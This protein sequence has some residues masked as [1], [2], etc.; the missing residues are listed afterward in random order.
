MIEYKGYKI[1]QEYYGEILSNEEKLYHYL[2]Y[3]KDGK[4]IGKVCCTDIAT[5]K[6]F[7]T[8][9]NKVRGIKEVPVK[10]QYLSNY[11]WAN[12]PPMSYSKDGDAG[13]DLRAA[14][15]EPVTLIGFRRAAHQVVEKNDG[16]N[17]TFNDRHTIIPCGI[18]VAIPEGYQLEIRPRSGLAAK[19]GV[20][21]VNSPGTVDSGYRGEIMAIMINHGTEDF[22]VQPGDRIAQGVLMP[23]YLAVF[24]PVDELDSSERGTGGLGSTGV[25]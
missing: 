7:D 23:Y 6:E 21:I 17:V 4:Y 25:K 9:L 10:I 24:T 19:N 22:V 14:I 11:N 16:Y 3:G 5:D 1:S 13:F 12:W 18:K 8:L 15:S 20:T 2:V